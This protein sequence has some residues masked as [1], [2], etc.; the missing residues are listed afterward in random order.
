MKLKHG[1]QGYC[2][3]ISVEEYEKQNKVYTNDAITTL[4]KTEEYK[5]KLP[6]FMKLS[7]ERKANRE[8]VQAE[9]TD[10]DDMFNDDYMESAF[11]QV[12]A[13]LKREK[14]LD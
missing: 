4:R 1:F 13:E 7:K 14:N 8:M 2:Q 5:D 3:R 10:E 6:I 9:Y 12:D 11:E